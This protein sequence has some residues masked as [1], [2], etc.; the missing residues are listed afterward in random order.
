MAL[1]DK[2]ADEPTVEGDANVVKLWQDA[3]RNAKQWKMIAKAYRNVLE[4]TLGDAFAI[5]VDGKKVITYRPGES[6][7][8]SQMQKDFPDLTQHYVHEVATSVFDV[9]LFVKAHPEI[10]EKY[11]VRSFRE[12][13]SG[14]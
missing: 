9:D 8:V 11:R 6:Y 4:D 3:E 10:A 13:N 5:T 7:A 2:H 14:E 12:V 1:P